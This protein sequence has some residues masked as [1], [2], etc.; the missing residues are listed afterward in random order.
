MGRG[1]SRTA[2]NTA[3]GGDAFWMGNVRDTVGRIGRVGC[4]SLPASQLIVGIFGH[5]VNR[6]C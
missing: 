3:A 1:G 4:G 5:A 6:L 2:R